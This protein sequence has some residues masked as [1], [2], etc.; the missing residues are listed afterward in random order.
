MLKGVLVSFTV[1]PLRVMYRF[2]S[3]N[4]FERYIL[5][6]PDFQS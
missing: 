5:C 4:L 6:T 1:I 2:D 3:V